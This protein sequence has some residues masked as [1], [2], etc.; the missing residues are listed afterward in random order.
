MFVRKNS[1]GV[2]NPKIVRS[3]TEN[4]CFASIF[5]QEVAKR[6]KTVSIIV[7]GL[8]EVIGFVRA[9]KFVGSSVCQ[10]CAFGPEML[11]AHHFS[12][13]RYPNPPKHSQNII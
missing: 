8:T 11:F 1:S 7:F 5:V 13:S 10:N 4:T 3:G 9:K 12:C 2:R 6:T